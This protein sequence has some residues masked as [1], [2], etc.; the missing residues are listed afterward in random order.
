M[1][2]IH[3]EQLLTSK[4]T[5]EYFHEAVQT[6]LVNQR[7]SVRGETIIYIVNLLTVFV[8]AERLFDLTP[9]GPMIKPL[10]LMYAEALEARTKAERD[11]ALQKLGDISLFISGLYAN[12]LSR[13]LVDVDY[14]IAMG[15]NAYGYL[16][17]S[18]RI[19]RNSC[20]L[21]DV[22]LELAQGFAGFVELLT[23]VGERTNVKTSNDILRLYEVWLCTGNE[24]AAKKLQSL[25]I[26]PVKTQRFTH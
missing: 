5:R 12:S 20:T 13:S 11:K 19:I 21:K 2:S 23:E 16:A 7:L 1:T 18:S 15:G 25:G 22:Y 3:N 8:R 26:Q 17:D 6:A 10:A 9:E 4:N 24:R 14:Y